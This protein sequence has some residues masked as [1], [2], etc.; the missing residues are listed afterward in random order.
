[1]VSLLSEK[2][3]NIINPK[4]RWYRTNKPCTNITEAFNAMNNQWWTNIQ[5]NNF[6]QL[7]LEEMKWQIR[8]ARAMEQNPF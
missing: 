5:K 2:I 6:G 8:K 7:G 3:V 4:K 1:M